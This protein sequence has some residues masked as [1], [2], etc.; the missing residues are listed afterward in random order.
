MLE[1]TALNKFWKEKQVL[2]D[3][4]FSLS[5]GK[6][7]GV[8]GANGSGKSTLLR[9]LA[10]EISTESGIISLQGQLIETMTRRERAQKIAVLTQELDEQPSFT[11]EEL[12]LMGRYPYQSFWFWDQQQDYQQA[13]RIMKETEIIHFRDRWFSDLSGGEKQRVL[14]AKLLM[15]EPDVLLLDE[16]TNHLDIHFQLT[17]LQKLKQMCHKKGMIMIT[18]LHDLNL[19][20]QYCDQIVLLKD[21]R[22]IAHGTP[23][24]L[25]QP[26]NIQEAF[27][28]KP[29]IINHPQLQV[30]QVLLQA[31][32]FE[33]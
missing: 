31:N 30:P 22:I 11:V 24:E 18:V 20:A 21:G 9:C 33:E 16:P 12:V 23:E 27:A 6:C 4:T 15:Q 13:E 5:V 17:L 32:Q 25:I 19:A 14:L 26:Q 1:V 3:V 7:L 28:V 8:L 29:L 10:G 2:Y